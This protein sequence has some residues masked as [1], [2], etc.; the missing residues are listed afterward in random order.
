[1]AT[2]DNNNTTNNDDNK[3]K[4]KYEEEVTLTKGL[5]IIYDLV[6]GEFWQITGRRRR[7]SPR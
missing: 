1:M 4:R 7:M 3:L 2:N 6:G 5:V